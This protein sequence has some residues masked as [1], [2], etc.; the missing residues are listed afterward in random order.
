LQAL[1]AAVARWYHPAAVVLWRCL[2]TSGQARAVVTESM[3]AKMIP[4]RGGTFVPISLFFGGN[5]IPLWMTNIGQG[6]IKVSDLTQAKYPERDHPGGLKTIG[7]GIPII[8]GILSPFLLGGCLGFC[9]QVYSAQM[10]I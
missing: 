9:A 10:N 3:R 2:Q 6:P 8:I 5:L 1:P 4:A 7:E